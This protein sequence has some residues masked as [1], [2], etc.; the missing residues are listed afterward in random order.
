MGC[1]SALWAV[2]LLLLCVPSVR[3][4]AGASGGTFLRQ[5][6]SAR[7]AGLSGSLTA[8]VDD[9]SALAL[10]PAGLALAIKPEI[11][12]T[13]VQLYEDTAL[14]YVGGV[15]PAKKWGGFGGAIFRQSTGGFERRAT[16]LESPTGFSITQTA[17]VGGW[18]V[19]LP[20]PG[21]FW[22]QARPLAFGVAIKGVDESLDTASASSIG[23]DA[24]VILRPTENFSLGAAVQNVMAPKLNFV[25]EGVAYDRI[26]D[27]SPAYLWRVNSTWRA[28]FMARATKSSEQGFS[29]AGG[30]EVAYKKQGW[31]RL[32]GQKDGYTGGLGWRVGNTQI[33][34]AVTTHELGMSHFLTM[35][36]RFG[37]TREEL[38]ETIKLGISKLNKG[39]AKS[40]AKV[41]VQRADVDLREERV[42]EALR[43]YEAAQLWDP[44]NKEIPKKIKDI[45]ERLDRSV[46][47][48]TLER[49]EALARQ[50]RQ[51]G[52]LLAARQYWNAALELKPDH[53]PAKAALA[54][55]DSQLSDDVKAK[56]KKAP[57]PTA[58]MQDA[59]RLMARGQAREARL[60][61]LEAR[62]R[63]D[64][65]ETRK[66]VE[67]AEEVL[68][69]S[70]DSRLKRA[71]ELIDT[72]NRGGA[73]ALLQS[74]L[75]DDPD[76]GRA[77][78][79][80][81]GLRQELR[82]DLDPEAR[83][84]VEQ[85]YY[86]AVERYLKGDYEAAEPLVKEILKLDP[87][88]DSAARLSEKLEA[89]RSLSK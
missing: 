41:Y 3:A 66:L 83:K 2:M 55:I 39:E 74:V 78:E 61:A 13:R 77:E 65:A 19:S 29:P 1:L 51:T 58:L 56:L 45:T 37:L 72:R 9:A 79:L 28:A 46:A 52:N 36:H 68:R 11:A 38:E 85:L 18:G 21:G 62:R 86:R 4:A 27:V 88:S 40:L 5:H 59:E 75:R 25:G 69:A 80:L 32:G 17:V 73:A 12:I 7:S 82:K 31:I 67:K 48:Q 26:I 50:A 20:L 44:E 53:A 30:I 15:L 43:G 81:G 33:D 76:N 35:T 89:S 10:N 70:V 49:T 6:P 63:S 87:S 16:P 22:S 71:Q 60:K 24:G 84:R 23:M 14:S 34:Y 42:A 8:L 47:R 54:E 57:G 64:T